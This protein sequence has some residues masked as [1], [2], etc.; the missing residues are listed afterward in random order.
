VD[1]N[2]RRTLRDPRT[3]TVVR[4]VVRYIGDYSSEPFTWTPPG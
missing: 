4:H 2:Q 3:G 1:T